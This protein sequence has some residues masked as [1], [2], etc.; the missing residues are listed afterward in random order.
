M[1][2]ARADP[3]PAAA[4]RGLAAAAPAWLVA[5]RASAA[6]RRVRVAAQ[7]AQ[8]AAQRA[9]AVALRAQAVALAAAAGRA[10]AR[11]AP[12]AARRAQAAARRAQAVA[13]RA[14]AVVEGRPVARVAAAPLE[15][16]AGFARQPATDPAGRRRPN[17][18][19]EWLPAP[20]RSDVHDQQRRQYLVSVVRIGP[21]HRRH[22]MPVNAAGSSSVKISARKRTRTST[23][24]GT[25][26]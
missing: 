3:P 24:F 15:R 13:L 14:P 17:D 2:A 19:S 20:L 26:S 18:D 9:P 5:P 21:L 16:S 8:A 12:A 22:E 4:A 7:R 11:R 25:R 23:P 10:V 1:P 6:A